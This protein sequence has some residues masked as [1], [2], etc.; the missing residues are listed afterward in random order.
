MYP[1][2]HPFTKV[3]QSSSTRQLVAVYS[4]Y[5]GSCIGIAAYSMKAKAPPTTPRAAMGCAA[6]AKPAPVDWVAV[7]AAVELV[8]EEA[9]VFMPEA[10]LA[11]SLVMATVLV[12]VV[13][14]PVEVMVD[15][16]S[17]EE[18]AV[19]VSVVVLVVD[20]VEDSVEED[21]VD[22]LADSVTLNWLD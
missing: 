2:E 3:P 22:E 14:E 7:A 18:V 6:I 15:T 5:R 13:L 21:E 16:A 9:A 8:V 1:R 11:A 10:V 12:L 19:V 4:R 20:E 17:L